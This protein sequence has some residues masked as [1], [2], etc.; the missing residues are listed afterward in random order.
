MTT[1]DIIVNNSFERGRFS[2]NFIFKDILLHLFELKSCHRNELLPM[3]K[4]LLLYVLILLAANKAIPK[5]RIT[6]RSK[7]WWNEELKLLRKE[8]VITKKN[9]Y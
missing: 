1:D 7:P 5:K 4:L 6:E 2:T 9:S 8:L 3:R